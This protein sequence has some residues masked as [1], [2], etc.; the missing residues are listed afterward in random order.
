MIFME[1]ISET[2]LGGWGLFF[3]AIGLI[4]AFAHVCIAFSE[5]LKNNYNDR[6]T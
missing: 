4:Q 2:T 1:I 6:K 5:I 3:I